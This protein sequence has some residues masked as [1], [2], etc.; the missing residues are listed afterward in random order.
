VRIPRHRG[1]QGSTVTVLIRCPIFSI[2]LTGSFVLP[3][4]TQNFGGAA[5]KIFGISSAYF[6][7]IESYAQPLVGR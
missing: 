2:L 7:W 3:P 4:Y 1:L 6:V 5:V